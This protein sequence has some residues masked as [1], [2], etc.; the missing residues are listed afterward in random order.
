[1]N[2]DAHA[3]R[4]SISTRID[5]WRQLFA[6]AHEISLGASPS[7][8]PPYGDCHVAAQRP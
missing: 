1:M 4:P 8:L 5:A 6:A 7:E 2:G 3:T